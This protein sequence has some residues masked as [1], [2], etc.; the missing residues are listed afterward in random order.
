MIDADIRLCWRL[1]NLNWLPVAAMGAVLLAAVLLTDFSLEPVVF[2]VTCAIALALASFAYAGG[3]ARSDR[4][5][6]RLV[7]MLGA[8]AQIVLATAIAGPLSYVALAPAW[9]LQDVALA[10]FDRAMGFESRSAILF[11]N[12]HPNLSN[13]LS[14][15]YG[16]IKW[17]LLVAPI[18]LAAT[19]RLVRLQQFVLAMTLGMLITIVISVFIPAIGNYQLLGLAA[20]DVPNVNMTAFAHLQHDIPLVRDGALRH[21]ELFKLAGVV[22][23]PSFH[24]A[25]AVMYAWAFAP[26][27]G[28]GPAA[29][30]LN[31]LMVAST[32]IVGG[33]YLTDVVGG[34]VLAAACIGFAKWRSGLESRRSAALAPALMLAAE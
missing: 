22:A 5:S 32:P 2:G 25:S 6:P 30:V 15:G 20:A 14:F 11:V 3:F 34:I 31:T 17:P 26:V 4:A 12:D 8:V 23:F 24:A 13:L 28:W 21:L 7:F 19:F 10:A 27:R 1:F 9:P 16:M 33:H 18:V 29:M